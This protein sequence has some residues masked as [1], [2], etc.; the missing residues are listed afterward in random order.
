MSAAATPQRQ[1]FP[2]SATAHRFLD[3]LDGIEIGGAAHNPFNIPGCRNVDFSADLTTEFK[4]LE[5]SYAGRT[6][7]VDIVAEGDR[8][9]LEDESLDYVLHSHVFE[10]FWDPIAAVKEW[11]RVLRP[12]GIIFA[13]VPHKERTMDA[14][15]PR[16]T[17]SELIDR[18]AGR[19]SMQ[20]QNAHIHHNI[21]ITADAVELVEYLGLEILAVQ[22]TDDK[23]GNGFTIVF[24]KPGTLRAAG[25]PLDLGC[26]AAKRAG[27]V[28]IDRRPLRD[29]DLVLDVERGRL[30]FDD[31]SVPS[32]YSN[33]LM[34]LLEHPAAVLREIVR[35]GQRNATVELWTPHAGSDEAHVDGAR[36]RFTEATWIDLL[37]SDIFD[38]CGGNLTLSEIK[39]GVA[40]PTLDRLAQGGIA[41]EFAIRYHVN[42]ISRI[43]AILTINKPHA[44]AAT[45][46]ARRVVL[47]HGS[48]V[49]AASNAC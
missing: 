20:P 15:K 8:L 42:V 1:I 48:A 27:S 32:F 7:P 19:L 25:R 26:G 21:W 13:I 44:P 3:G 12:G 45:T 31:S 28:G 23:V 9:P 30:P 46:Y 29:V 10:H 5:H 22:D 38:D 11:L 33:G 16:T 37:S 17:L 2:D 14:H 43:G 18:H 36:R 24:R 39:L 34:H 6:L 41:L 47:D 49:Q 4:V 35:V 40:Q